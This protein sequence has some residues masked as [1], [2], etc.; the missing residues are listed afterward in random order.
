MLFIHKVHVQIILYLNNLFGFDL[1]MVG[2]LPV[3]RLDP[4]LLYSYMNNYFTIIQKFVMNIV[5]LIA[6]LLCGKLADIYLII[7]YDTCKLIAQV[8]S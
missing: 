3:L 5:T 8:I 4:T 7:M 6:N 2:S 1:N